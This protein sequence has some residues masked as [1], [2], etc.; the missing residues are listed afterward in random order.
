MLD[1]IH[2]RNDVAIL[3]TAAHLQLHVVV[4]KHMPPV[5]A[6]KEWIG[7]LGEGHAVAF[8][9][10]VLN[11]VIDVSTSL[12]IRMITAKDLRTYPGPA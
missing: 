11:P 9:H 1:S 6:L 12:C 5:P 7:K 8:L 10:L 2:A 4:G 3:V